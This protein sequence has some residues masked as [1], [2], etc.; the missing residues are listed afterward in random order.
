MQSLD[1]IH[2][3]FSDKQKPA[4][5][6]CLLHHF[7]L[8]D[9]VQHSFVTSHL[10]CLQAMHIGKEVIGLWQHKHCHLPI[11]QVTPVLRRSD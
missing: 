9:I 2:I 4:I 8:K 10:P 5:V 3:H 7:F 1:S 6:V 11:K